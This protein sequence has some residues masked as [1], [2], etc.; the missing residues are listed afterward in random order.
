MPIV[1]VLASTPCHVAPPLLPC[2]DGTQGGDWV[3]SICRGG[4]PT[5]SRVRGVT[6]PPWLSVPVRAGGGVGEGVGVALPPAASPFPFWLA[7]LPEVLDWSGGGLVMFCSATG[8]KAAM[9]GTWGRG[10]CS[11][12]S[13]ASTSRAAISAWTSPMRRPPRRAR[14]ATTAV[15]TL[16]LG[17]WLRC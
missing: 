11:A 16:S 4:L 14:S 5:Q 17:P 9:G 15:A 10:G 1:M 6:V 8:A 12:G 7:P 2:Q 3:S 13:R